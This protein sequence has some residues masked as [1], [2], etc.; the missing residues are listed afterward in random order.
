MKRPGLYE[1]SVILSFIIMP[2]TAISVE[3]LVIDPS[4]RLAAIAL[5]WFIFCGIGL[6]LGMAG[7]KQIITPQ[8]TA[9]E[10]FKIQDEGIL[11]IIRELGL[12][13]LC[14]SVIA[15]ISL[16]IP[17]FR[18]PAGIA[19]GLYFGLAGLL[20][21]TKPKDSKNEIFALVSDISIF[22]VIGVL[23]IINL[24]CIF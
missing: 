14:F 19:G 22:L 12:A 18:I 9:R 23:T 24:I 21:I 3:V 8:F 15:I 4:P 2:L 11:P 13:N 6:R 10:I 1:W 17:T 5:K 7:I 20:H 16:F